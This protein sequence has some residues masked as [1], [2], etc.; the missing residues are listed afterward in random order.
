M[1]REDMLRRALECR[2]WAGTARSDKAKQDFLKAAE[3]WDQ[4]AGDAAAI[5]DTSR[6]AFLQIFEPP[7]GTYHA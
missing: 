4:L 5:D 7:K 2:C 6:D 1:R 3:T